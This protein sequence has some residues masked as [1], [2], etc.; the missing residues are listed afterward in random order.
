[1]KVFNK[2]G[3]QGQITSALFNILRKQN[4][5]IYVILPFGLLLSGTDQYLCKQKR[6]CSTFL[7]WCSKTRFGL[8][9]VTQRQGRWIKNKAY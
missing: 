7:K 4:Y 1:M 3:V 8:Q 6:M 9:S 2:D 5:Y